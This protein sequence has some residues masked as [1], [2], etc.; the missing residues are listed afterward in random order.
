MTNEKQAG[1]QRSGAADIL[2]HSL[3][4]ILRAGKS[5]EWAELGNSRQALLKAC[6]QRGG[7]QVGLAEDNKHGRQKERH[8]GR[9]KGV[10]GE[11]SRAW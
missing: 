10:E 2:I 6:I 7:E 11:H 8:V 5:N 1:L 4:G 9:L 3:E